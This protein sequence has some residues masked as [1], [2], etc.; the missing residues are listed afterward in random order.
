MTDTP[1]YRCAGT[2]YGTLL[3]HR[4][5]LHAL[6]AAVSQAPYKAPPQAPVLY[7]KPRNTFAGQGAEVMIPARMSELEVGA[8]LGMVF[9][10]TACRVSEASALDFVQGY[11]IVADISVP[12]TAFYRPSVRFKARD[13]Y[14]PMGPRLVARADIPN[15]DDL[16]VRVAIDG[17]VVQRA[18]TQDMLRPAARLIAQVSDFMTFQAGDVLLLGVAH[19]APRARAGQHAALEIDGLGRL[20]MS[21]H[22]AQENVP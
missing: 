18:G 22:T 10:R 19:G 14:C 4:A 16:E 13:G 15:P 2:V 9:A 17:R 5:A 6:G 3:N 11:I 12:H 7:I 1:A 8:S 21:F 20:E